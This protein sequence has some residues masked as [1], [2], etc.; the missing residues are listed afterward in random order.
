LAYTFLTVNQNHLQATV[1]NVTLTVNTRQTSAYD[2]YISYQLGNTMPTC[3]TGTTHSITQLLH[4]RS[5]STDNFAWKAQHSRRVINDNVERHYFAHT[6]EHIVNQRAD[7]HSSA[8]FLD[9]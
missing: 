4:L 1:L 6:L 7:I 8:P 2:N 5:K 3:R 9:T